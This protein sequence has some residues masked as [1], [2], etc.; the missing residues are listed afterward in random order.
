RRGLTR[1]CRVAVVTRALLLDQLGLELGAERL[2]RGLLPAQVQTHRDLL[3]PGLWLAPLPKAPVH[4]LGAGRVKN[5]RGLATIS[6][7]S[8]CWACERRSSSICRFRSI[9]SRRSI[10]CSR[11]RSAGRQTSTQPGEAK[12]SASSSARSFRGG[13]SAIALGG[14]SRFTR[15]FTRWRIGY[16]PAIT[17]AVASLMRPGGRL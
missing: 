7:N 15:G 3:F 17:C 6:D 9:A 4:R 12:R 14:R 11:A 13:G 8:S 2:F 5:S 16:A 1:G 10:C